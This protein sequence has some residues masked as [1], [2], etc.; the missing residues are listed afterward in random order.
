MDC[1]RKDEETT[2]LSR[3]YGM[4]VTKEEIKEKT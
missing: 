1:R 4:N 3:Y 2:N